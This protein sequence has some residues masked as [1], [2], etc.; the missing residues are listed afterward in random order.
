MLSFHAGNYR[1]L[2]TKFVKKQ[3]FFPLSS[4]PPRARQL[5][6]L[7]SLVADGLFTLSE[8]EGQLEK[9]KTFKNGAMLL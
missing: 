8:V 9:I 6:A 2:S 1:S 3:L 5:K 7:A 4:A